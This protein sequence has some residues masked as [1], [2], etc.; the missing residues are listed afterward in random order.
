MTCKSESDKWYGEFCNSI[1]NGI[2]KKCGNKHHKD[3]GTCKDGCCDKW[4][5][6]KCGNTFLIELG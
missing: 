4:E 6:T 3:I 2:C 5:C 1:K